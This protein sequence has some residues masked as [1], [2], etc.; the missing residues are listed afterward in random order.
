MAKKTTP[1]KLGKDIEQILQKRIKG[2][3]QQVKKAVQLGAMEVRNTA[4]LDISRGSKTGK[5]YEKYNPRRTHVA[6]R[7][8]EAPATDTG[9]LVSQITTE[10]KVQGQTVIGQIISSAPYSKYLEFG[11]INRD[12]SFTEERPFM[13]PALM[14]NREKIKKIFIREGV[15]KK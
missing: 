9:F 4:I 12:G 8:G 7:G 1:E 5:T 2:R 14:K 10:V 11:H 15:I 6:S 3:V 13:Q